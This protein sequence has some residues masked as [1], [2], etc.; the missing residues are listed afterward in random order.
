M[1]EDRVVMESIRRIARQMLGYNSPVYRAASVAL[2]NFEVVRKE[3]V[4]MLATVKRLESGDGP[5]EPVSF[6]NLKHPL[7]VRPGTNDVHT[8]LDTVVREE[9]GKYL[10]DKDLLTLIDAGAFIGDTSA[11]FLSRFP[12]LRTWALEP[13][14]DNLPLVR[15]NLARY[16]DRATVLPLAL[17]GQEGIVHF[18]GKA[19]GGSIADQGHEVKTTTVPGLLAQIPGG[20]V[21]VLKIDIEGAEMEV[22][23]STPATWMPKVGLIIVELH[24]PDIERSALKIL[25]KHDFQ[26]EQYRSVWYCRP[27]WK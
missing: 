17:A 5:P 21:D 18:A 9:Y 8:V 19:T 4:G 7:D 15:R 23:A 22:F 13:N 16:G 6:R 1:I 24:G 27:V 14:P 20:Y 11:Y 25:K 2:T 12:K 10:P 3:G 26:V